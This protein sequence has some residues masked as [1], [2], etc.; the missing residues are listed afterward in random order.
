MKRDVS[1]LWMRRIWW[2][3][4][5]RR[6]VATQ[7]D[8]GDNYYCVYASSSPATRRWA[9]FLDRWSSFEF[10]PWSVY[11]IFPKWT[12]FPVNF[13]YKIRSWHTHQPT[14]QPVTGTFCA[15]DFPATFCQPTPPLPTCATCGGGDAF[16]E[17]EFSCHAN[18]HSSG[19]AA[20]YFLTHVLGP[21][22]FEWILLEMMSLRG[23]GDEWALKYL[24]PVPMA[25]T[26]NPY[27]DDDERWMY[28]YF[29]C[30]EL[31]FLCLLIN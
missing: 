14:R 22:G 17:S 20:F 7:D 8:D 24:S 28:I 6:K 29:I 13:S 18:T 26:R 15:G 21:R 12:N 3:M 11:R 31:P 19:L 5:R 4:R 16:Y 23:V 10:L 27:Y 30:M 2:W 1:P 9:G 25:I